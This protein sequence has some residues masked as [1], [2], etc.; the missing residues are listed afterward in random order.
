M[1]TIVFSQ[2][3]DPA[4]YLGQWYDRMDLKVECSDFIKL[5]IGVPNKSANRKEDKSNPKS[6]DVM[7]FTYNSLTLQTF[8]FLDELRD[9]VVK[10]KLYV[11]IYDHELKMRIGFRY[12]E[13]KEWIEQKN[14]EL[15]Y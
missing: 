13:E 8:E 5:T 15:P 4:S 14:I 7:L 12:D 10:N 11:F 2:W 6:G 9:Y 3:Y 1:I